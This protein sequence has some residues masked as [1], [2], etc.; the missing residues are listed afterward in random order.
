ML[1]DHSKLRQ[2][3]PLAKRLDWKV[4]HRLIQQAERARLMPPLFRLTHGLGME[5]SCG[6]E[7]LLQKNKK[8]DGPLLQPAGTEQRESLNVP[9]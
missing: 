7:R 1:N 6:V 3:V 2:D 8:R 9:V 4:F 5:Q